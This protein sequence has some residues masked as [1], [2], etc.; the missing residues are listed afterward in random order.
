LPMI[1]AALARKERRPLSAAVIQIIAF[2][3]TG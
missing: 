1:D 2:S 3:P